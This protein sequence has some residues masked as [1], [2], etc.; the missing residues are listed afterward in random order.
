[1]HQSLP[2]TIDYIEMPSRDL[3]QTRRFF[4]DLFGWEFE[5]Y[6]PDYIAFDDGRTVGGFFH[7]DAVWNETAA[8]PLVVFYAADL[9]ATR[10]DVL[11]LGG[12]VTREIFEFP[13][14]FR[15]HFQAPASGE[16]AV[17]SEKE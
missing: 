13:G 8:C 3:A 12:N 4:A 14:G 6:G 16:F 15:F 7:A 9:G 2:R 11:R 5:D 17:W 1:M 10:N